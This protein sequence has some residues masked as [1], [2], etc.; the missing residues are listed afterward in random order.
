MVHVGY[1][2]NGIHSSSYQLRFPI[3]DNPKEGIIAR[4]PAC[5][6]N[7]KLRKFSDSAYAHLPTIDV[8]HVEINAPAPDE[9]ADVK[10]RLE[11]HGSRPAACSARWRSNTTTRTRG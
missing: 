1:I 10:A 9:V 8:H 7:G 4:Q 2:S 3:E 6:P 11:D 5:V